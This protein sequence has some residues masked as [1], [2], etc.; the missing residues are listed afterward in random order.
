M[1]DQDKR[2]IVVTGGSRGL[3]RAICLAFAGPDT[4][5][6]FNYN[7]SETSAVE[8]S[9]LIAEAGGTA[10]FEQVDVASLEQVSGFIFGFIVKYITIAPTFFRL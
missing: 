8:T 2:I 9:R 1:T 4:H 3:G 7:A 5:I 10:T 6:C